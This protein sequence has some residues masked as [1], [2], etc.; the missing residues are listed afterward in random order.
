ML[1]INCD[2]GARGNPG[3]AASA[4]VVSKDGQIIFSKGKFLGE[5][6]NNVAEYEGVLLGINYLTQNQVK[7]DV[8]FVLDSLLVVNQLSGKFKI[9][10][11]NLLTL[12]KKINAE[13]KTL[14][15]KIFYTYVPREKNKEADKLVNFTLDENR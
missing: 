2:G 1:T 5:S 6:T 12:F 4:C 14:N 8:T 9:N 13:A 11:A 15:G 7:E 3:P 10:N